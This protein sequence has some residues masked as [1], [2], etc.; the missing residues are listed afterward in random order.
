MNEK[1]ILDV[2]N[3]FIADIQASPYFIWYIILIVMM[4][5][6]FLLCIYIIRILIKDLLCKRAIRARNASIKH[7]ESMMKIRD[8]RPKTQKIVHLESEVSDF[9]LPEFCGDDSQ[10]KK[11]IISFLE[12]NQSYLDTL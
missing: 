6:M 2:L 7:L 4:F 1:S 3:S 12:L 10:N 9:I 11:E 8:I 5:L